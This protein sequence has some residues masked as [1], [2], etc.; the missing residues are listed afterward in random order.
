MGDGVKRM[1]PEDEQTQQ[2]AGGAVA[3]APAAPPLADP[4]AS[5]RSVSPA[6]PPARRAAQPGRELGAVRLLREVG[7]GATGSVFLGHHTVLGRDV[8]VK[9]LVNVGPARQDRARLKR[10]LDEAR[11][12]AAVRHPNLTQIYHADVDDED[13]TPYL[14]LEYVSG[15]TL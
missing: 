3:A 12:A 9:F 14:V 10:F 5:P 15:P 11:A 13:G 8:A 6:A 7:R 1:P 2:L 4:P